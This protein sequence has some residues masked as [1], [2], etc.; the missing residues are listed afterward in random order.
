M[1]S[2]PP[3]ISILL[4]RDFLVDIYGNS[5]YPGS[6][7]SWGKVEIEYQYFYRTFYKKFFDGLCLRVISSVHAHTYASNGIN[8]SDPKLVQKF[9]VQKLSKIVGP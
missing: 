9:N 6:R 4:A 3:L 8:R 1:H 2:S 7:Y 5:K